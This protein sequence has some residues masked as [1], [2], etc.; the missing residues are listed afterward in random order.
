MARSSSA[1][2]LVLDAGQREHVPDTLLAVGEGQQS[3]LVGQDSGDV[4]QYLPEEVQRV[5]AHDHLEGPV[6]PGEST[7]D[8]HAPEA[9]VSPGGA[10]ATHERP[11]IQ[12]VCVDSHDDR[13]RVASPG[14][15]LGHVAETAPQVEH[16]SHLREIVALERLLA[17]I[18]RVRGVP[19]DDVRRGLMR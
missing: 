15:L 16:R 5:A 19:P 18:A 7:A 4:R 10:D 8:T 3:A 9:C 17:H 2:R 6:G 11:P 1:E 14:H 13:V 12:A